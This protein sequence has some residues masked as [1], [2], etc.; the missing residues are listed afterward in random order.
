M[1]MRQHPKKQV[2]LT[3]DSRNRICLTPFLPDGL[4]VTS[5]KAYQEGDKIILEPMTEIPAREAW[6]YQNPTALASVLEGLKQA[7]D[8]RVSELDIDYSEFLKDEDDV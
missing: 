1:V 3:L 2:S 8:G 7:E 6:L 4:N 5:Y